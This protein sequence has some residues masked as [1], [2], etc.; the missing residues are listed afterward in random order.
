MTMWQRALVRFARAVAFGAI[1]T[2]ATVLATRSLDEPITWQIV[3]T[4]LVIGGLMAA[5][6]WIRDSLGEKQGG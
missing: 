6:K 5:D 3:I 1:S 2:T 4:P